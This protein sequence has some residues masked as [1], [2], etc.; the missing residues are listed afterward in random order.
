MP[1]F[2]ITVKL[3]EFGMMGVVLSNVAS[4]MARHLS[5]E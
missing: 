3:I 1:M 5:K 4:K 2:D